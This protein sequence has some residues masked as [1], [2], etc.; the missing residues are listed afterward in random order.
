MSEIPYSVRSGRTGGTASI[1]NITGLDWTNVDDN[2]VI[3]RKD[4]TTGEGSGMK[5]TETTVGFD[6]KKTLNFFNRA[7]PFNIIFGAIE[8]IFEGLA[9]SYTTHIAPKSVLIGTSYG[10]FLKASGLSNNVFVGINKSSPSKSLEVGTT[11]IADDINKFVGIN[12]IP[13]TD[14]EILNTFYANSTTR[15]VGIINAA[16]T[17]TFQVG[18]LMYVNASTGKVGIGIADPDEELEVDGSIQIDSAS[19]AKLKFQKSGSSPH[20]IGE[21]DGV[22]DGFNGGRL[23]FYTKETGGAVTKKMDIKENGRVDILTDNGTFNILS[24]DGISQQAFLYNSTTGTKDFTIESSSGVT[25]KGITLTTQGVQ[26]FRVGSN[27]EFGLGASNSTGI[28]GESIISQGPNNP[29]IWNPNYK[30]YASSTLTGDFT[31]NLNP[32]QPNA[33]INT[34]NSLFVT[35]FE[36]HTNLIPTGIFTAPRAGKYFFTASFKLSTPFNATTVM[37]IYEGTT[38]RRM[39]STSV[40]QIEN[41]RNVTIQSILD[42]DVN[43]TAFVR[44]DVDANTTIQY[45]SYANLTNKATKIDVFSVD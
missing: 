20:A 17:T 32:A 36:S 35:D 12:T 34:P 3:R 37:E 24:K 2:E 13:T 28:S 26:R 4:A 33:F 42:L 44:M 1:N 40:P 25:A 27:G 14:L 7:T 43:E 22:K 31:L 38:G 11:L 5:F 15:K 23:E 6:Y 18:T 10:L 19:E 39:T 8:Y 30:V 45:R 29:P 16:P 21:I 9:N 41:S